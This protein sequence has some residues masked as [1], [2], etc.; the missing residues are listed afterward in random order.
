[1]CQYIKLSLKLSYSCTRN[2]GQIIKAHN[3]KILKKDNLEEEERKCNCT[4]IE[5]CPMKKENDACRQ[6]N[7]IYKATVETQN[8]TRNYI[9][10]TSNE[11]KERYRTHRQSFKDEKHENKT[12]LSKYI[13]KIK[14]ENKKFEIKWK[15][16]ARASEARSG[17]KICRLCLK[18][19]LAILNS[20]KNC[21][22]QN[23]EFLGTC[24]HTSK[25]LLKNWK[26]KAELDD[27]T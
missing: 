26:R 17:Q 20:D 8:E 24:R 19:I 27:V 22:N 3:Q 10:L 4:K 7:V 6:K 2:I 21:L 9:G 1:M 14:R 16:I 11:L 13:W 25:F 18:E 23:N 15:I 12:K 5:I